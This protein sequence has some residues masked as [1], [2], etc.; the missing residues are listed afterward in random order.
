MLTTQ[1]IIFFGYN[2]SMRDWELFVL[3]K[4]RSEKQVF[5]AGTQKIK[6]S[7]LDLVQRNEFLF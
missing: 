5:E 7:N 6:I 4:V 1:K 3:N 2:Q